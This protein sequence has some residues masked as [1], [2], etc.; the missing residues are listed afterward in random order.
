VGGIVNCDLNNEGYRMYQFLLHEN[1]SVAI[2]KDERA[3]F[4]R[5]SA[6][7]AELR[8]TQPITQ[9]QFAESLNVSQQIVNAF[10][11]GRRRMPVSAL[12]VIAKLLGV[13]L[14]ELVGEEPRAAKRGP[15]PKL[16]QQTERIQQLP[17]TRQR[18]V[19]QMLE[20]VLSLARR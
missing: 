8:K 20:G 7:I 16:Q 5:L 4:E 3:F 15:S 18:L 9:V 17:K 6:R 12:P 14:E 19:M 11:I 10:E 13:S 2:S 1:D